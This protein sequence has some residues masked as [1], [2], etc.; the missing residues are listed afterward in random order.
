MEVEGTVG[1]GEVHIF[2][3]GI[4]CDVLDS[5][6]WEHEVFLGQSSAGDHL[7][8]ACSAGIMAVGVSS[9][10]S[11]RQIDTD[12]AYGT[13]DPADGT[14]AILENVLIGRAVETVRTVQCVRVIG[15]FT[16]DGISRALMVAR[17]YT[18]VSTEIACRNTGVVGL[19]V[20][21]ASMISSP[22]YNYVQ[23]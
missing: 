15:S 5:H 9:V 6:A 17:L 11:F 1:A 12:C 3:C 16:A 2:G 13:T 10:N 7:L 20:P 8:C 19:P 18:G 23:N 21:V 4:A 14:F 22:V